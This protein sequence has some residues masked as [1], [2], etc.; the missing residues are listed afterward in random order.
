MGSQTAQ[1][2]QFQRQL[3]EGGALAMG[4]LVFKPSEVAT[5][6]EEWQM[7]KNANKLAEMLT[8]KDGVEK[9]KELARTKPTTAKAQT[10]VNSIIGGG[11]SQ[12]DDI[13]EESK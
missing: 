12:K 7:G 11:V 8:S 6:Y 4:K 1:N 3:G 9:L 10:I 2:T 5:K 13:K